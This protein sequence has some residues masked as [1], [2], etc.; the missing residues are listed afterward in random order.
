[1]AAAAEYIFFPMSEMTSHH[2]IVDVGTLFLFTNSNNENFNQ[3]RLN[4]VRNNLETRTSLNTFDFK[5]FPS[6]QLT[7]FK[8][9]SQST[10]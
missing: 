5:F 3:L 1:M 8:K 9:I 4:N 10:R 6:K 2:T 7:V